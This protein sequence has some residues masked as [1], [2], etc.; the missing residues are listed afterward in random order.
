MY[1]HDSFAQKMHIPIKQITNQL[2][3]D[4]PTISVLLYVE[5]TFQ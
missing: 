4:Y 1:K 3:P 2:K 5:N